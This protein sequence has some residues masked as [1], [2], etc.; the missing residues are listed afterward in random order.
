MWHRAWVAISAALPD[1]IAATY[2]AAFE[3]SGWQTLL[4]RFAAATRSSH[5]TLLRQDVGGRSGLLSEVL[6]VDPHYQRLYEDHYASVNPW[7]Q[8]SELLEP[9]RVCTGESLCDANVFKR[10]E[11]A[12][13]YLRPQDAFHMLGVTLV[14]S[15]GRYAMLS[16]L[17]SARGGPYPAADVAL[18][19]ALVPHL[20]RAAQLEERLAAIHAER[21]A[22]TSALDALPVGVILLGA[23]GE[24]MAV[25]RRAREIVDAGDGIGLT[26]DGVVA[27]RPAE[28]ARLRQKIGEAQ[29]TARGV[30][31]GAGGLLLLPRPSLL[32]PL[33]VLVAPLRA[34]RVVLGCDAACVALFVADPEHRP[35][36]SGSVLATL[37]GLTPAESRLASHLAAGRTIEEAS[38]ELGI[39]LGTARTHLKH[40]LAKTGARRQSELVGLV[41]GG[42]AQ[43]ASR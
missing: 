19:D 16:A 27:A 30:G 2:D 10:T 6:G 24:V 15:E 39:A 21:D 38:A 12:N 17:R 23:R 3:P 41:L 25:N 37:Y 28:T 1:L 4:E 9:G 29:Q 26:R 13:D 22:S 35:I 20:Q 36:A 7:M 14:K 31:V 42:I 34:G 33:Q 11:F 18:L 43:L 40:V 8:R 5:A 32:R